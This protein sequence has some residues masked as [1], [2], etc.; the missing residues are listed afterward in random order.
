MG[1]FEI[2]LE[3]NK[4]KYWQDAQEL[5]KMKGEINY[6]LFVVKSFFKHLFMFPI[7]F[8][9]LAILFQST[10]LALFIIFS[11]VVGIIVSMNVMVPDMEK[12]DKLG[13]PHYNAVSWRGAYE[14]YQYKKVH[15]KSC[16]ILITYDK[17]LNQDLFFQC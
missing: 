5:E 13:I 6:R 10:F 11:F 9:V 14:I 2:E 7:I 15:K 4:Q 12:F 17:K 3:N 8:T 16:Y 1:E